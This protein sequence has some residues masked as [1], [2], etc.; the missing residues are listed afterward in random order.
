MQKLKGLWIPAEILLNEDLTDKEKLILSMILYLSNE[1]GSSFASN[2]YVASI[3]NITADR[4]SKIISSL[5]KKGYIEVVLKFKAEYNKKEFD[6]EW[7]YT[8]KINKLEKE[9]Y[10]LHRVVNKFK[11]YEICKM[12][13]NVVLLT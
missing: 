2:K 8:N 11:V 5:K 13:E 10:F 12:Q 6:L 4:V 9:N 7:K 3:V 1:T